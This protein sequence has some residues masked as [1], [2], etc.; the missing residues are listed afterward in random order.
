MGDGVVV[1]GWDVN[2]R[3]GCSF[4]AVGSDP[5]EQFGNVSRHGDGDVPVGPVDLDVNAQVFVSLPV[6]L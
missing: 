1:V 3:R 2:T 4:Q 6:D 5:L